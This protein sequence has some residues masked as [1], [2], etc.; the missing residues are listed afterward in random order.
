[1]FTSRA[2]IAPP[3]TTVCEYAKYATW[4]YVNIWI[5]HSYETKHLTQEYILLLRGSA[6]E[7]GG[8]EWQGMT[9]LGKRAIYAT[10]HN[11]LRAFH[12]KP[13]GMSR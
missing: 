2:R 4:N 8:A 10:R 5:K 7:V 11:M 3:D 6:R 13:H 1:M 9:H 12:F